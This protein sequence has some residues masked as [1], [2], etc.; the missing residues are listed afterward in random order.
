MREAERIADT[1]AAMAVVVAFF[2]R[3]S[4]IALFALGVAAAAVLVALALW[5]L[6]KRQSTG[7]PPA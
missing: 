4:N 2:M 6:R 3:G 5:T 7:G 1:V